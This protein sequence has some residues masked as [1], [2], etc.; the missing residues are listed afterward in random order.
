MSRRWLVAVAVL[1]AGAALYLTR[2]NDP[3]VVEWL[4]DVGL[5]SVA[6]SLRVARVFVHAHVSVPSAV[7]S[8]FS[9]AAWAF[10]FGTILADAP[11]AILAL[12]SVVLVGH[13][14]AQG[15]GLVAGTFDLVDLVVLGGGFV[16]AVALF[17]PRTRSC[18]EGVAS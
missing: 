10:A 8:F 5:P 7:R 16:T 11:R 3:V 15:L 1:A 6:G 14:L 13:E 12:G 17:R 4:D 2:A 9:D 18:P